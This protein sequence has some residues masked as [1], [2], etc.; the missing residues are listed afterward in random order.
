M[1][2]WAYSMLHVSSQQSESH[3]QSMWPRLRRTARGPAFLKQTC[4]LLMWAWRVSSLHKPPALCLQFSLIRNN[5]TGT[6]SPIKRVKG[7]VGIV[8]H[9]QIGVSLRSRG[10]IYNLTVAFRVRYHRRPTL[11]FQGLE[12][13]IIQCE[14]QSLCFYLEIEFGGLSSPSSIYQVRLIYMSLSR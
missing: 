6:G 1:Q 12:I 5:C 11:F 3:Y 2:T 8:R 10:C 13:Q 4:I 9:T 14:N 7:K